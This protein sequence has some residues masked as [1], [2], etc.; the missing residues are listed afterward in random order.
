VLE[1]LHAQSYPQSLVTYYEKPPSNLCPLYELWWDSDLG[2]L[3]FFL[4]S[5]RNGLLGLSLQFTSMP[6]ILTYLQIHN[7]SCFVLP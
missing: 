3:G 7:L 6:H 1:A 2:Q 4:R 5:M